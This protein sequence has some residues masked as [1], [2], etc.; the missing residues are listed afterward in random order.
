M[1]GVKSAVTNKLKVCENIQAVLS[2]TRWYG[3]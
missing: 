2:A 3:A 1:V